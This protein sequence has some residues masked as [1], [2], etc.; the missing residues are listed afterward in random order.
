MRSQLDAEISGGVTAFYE[1]QITEHKEQVAN[2]KLEVEMSEKKLNVHNGNIVKLLEW[3]EN[4]KVAT[5]KINKETQQLRLRMVAAKQAIKDIKLYRTLLSHMALGYMN[6]DFKARTAKENLQ[7]DL[8][9]LCTTI[10]AYGPADIPHEN[11]RE[12][13]RWRHGSY[14]FSKNH[15][16]W[17]KNGTIAHRR[18]IQKV[19]LNRYL[20]NTHEIYSV[21][22]H[23]LAQLSKEHSFNRQRTQWCFQ[24]NSR[25]TSLA[26]QDERTL[27]SLRYSHYM[28]CDE[29]VCVC[30]CACA[31]V[32]VCV[33]VSACVKYASTHRS[34]L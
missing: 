31:C 28:R 33:C 10:L 21:L 20:E 13:E 25:L 12:L 2:L 30:V 24:E 16:L 8:Q 1:A 34:L 9:E 19:T 22:E 7:A 14:E 5:G 4:H 32:C 29:C 27:D 3:H 26:V 18:G 6:K 23:L 17:R 11:R 15:R